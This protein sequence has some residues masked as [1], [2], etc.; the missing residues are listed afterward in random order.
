LAPGENSRVTVG[1]C[2]GV[3]RELAME[4][5]VEG[6]DGA[7]RGPARWVRPLRFRLP[8]EQ[9]RDRGRGCVVDFDVDQET[10]VTSH[11]I[12][13]GGRLRPAAAGDP[14]LE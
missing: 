3:F 1:G 10:V 2:K 7:A 9:Y 8:I 5:A 6:G 4:F 14:G 12:F 11:R 13:E